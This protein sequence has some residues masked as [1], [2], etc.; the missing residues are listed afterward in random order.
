MTNEFE[1]SKLKVYG[2]CFSIS[3]SCPLI[4]QMAEVIIECNEPYSLIN[5]DD[6]NFTQEWTLEPDNYTAEEPLSDVE[7]SFKYHVGAEKLFINSCF[8]LPE[9]N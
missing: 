2:N 1:E 6:R 9:N 3:A 4:D 7:A 8:S 5:E